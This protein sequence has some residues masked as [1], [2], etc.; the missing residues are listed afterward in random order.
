MVLM[1]RCRSNPLTK[2][3]V[4][5]AGKCVIVVLV[6]VGYAAPAAAQRP[7][8]HYLHG[9]V[10]PPGAIGAA[11]LQRAEGLS[12]YFQPVEVRAP[13]GVL[14]SLA[15]ENMFAAA[16]PAPMKAGLLVGAVYR[17]RITNLPDRPGAELF[18]TIE[19]INRLRPPPGQE[20]RFP[21]PVELSA[22]EIEFALQGKMVTRVIY[23]EAPDSAIPVVDDPKRQFNFEV[24]PTENPLEV[25]DRLGRPM[26]ILRLGGRVPNSDGPDAAF[27]YGSPPAMQF[28][29]P[30]HDGAELINK[31]PARQTAA[32]ATTPPPKATASPVV[33][34]SASQRIKSSEGSR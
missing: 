11:Q 31:K 18:P 30:Q 2:S 17:L 6:S 10:L 14:V 21:I 32:L 3:V 27:M 19:V 7:P 20:A 15:V 23:L 25:A 1:P 12:G 16:Q 4:R 28:Y 24:G 33:R 8:V 9:G 5:I 34:T 13:G 26:A 29:G 22:D